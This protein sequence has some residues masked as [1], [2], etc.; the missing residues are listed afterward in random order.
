[1]THLARGLVPKQGHTASAQV[2][3]HMSHTQGW[4]GCL[5]SS[6]R[7]IYM[8]ICLLM[9]R[10]GRGENALFFSLQEKYVIILHF[11]FLFPS[12]MEHISYM[13]CFCTQVGPD[14][15]HR[16]H[17][18]FYGRN[19]WAIGWPV[20]HVLGLWWSVS[21]SIGLSSTSLSESCVSHTYTNSFVCHRVEKDRRL[22]GG[23]ESELHSFK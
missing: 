6:D 15:H 10:Q 8:F 12:S 3:L 20:S 11:R 2:C 21:M 19:S 22:C 9:C 16:S 17:S 18:V 7:D 23:R 5:V 1:M 14:H 4:E 13:S